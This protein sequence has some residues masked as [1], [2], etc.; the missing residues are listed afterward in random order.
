MYLLAVPSELWSGN[1]TI[2]KIMLHTL[3]GPLA[4]VLFPVTESL[5]LPFEPEIYYI[6][7][8]II[9]LVPLYLLIIEDGHG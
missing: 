8:W 4:A 5:I 9:L 6:Q 1:Q 2:Y 3:H 7:H